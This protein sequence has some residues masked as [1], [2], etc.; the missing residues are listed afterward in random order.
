MGNILTVERLSKNFGGLRAVDGVSF[1]AEERAIT[2]LIGPNGAGKTTVFNLISGF[3]PTET[4][5]IDFRGDPIQ[6]LP[7]FAIARKGIARTFQDP[8]IFPSET[9]L[10]NVIVGIRQRGEHPFWALLGGPRIAAERRRVRG[11]AE[12]ILDTVGLLARARE[13]AGDLSFGEQRFLSIARSLV[14]DPALILM[15]EPTVGL[16]RKS[17]DKL[18]ALMTRLVTVDGKALLVIE[19]NMDVVMSV[20]AKVVLLVQGGVVASGV[21][22]EVKQHRSMAEAYLGTKHAAQSL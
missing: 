14:C 15:D 18:L 2:S 20:S 5:T 22:E 1:T 6:A 11:R 7:P 9:V 21:P 4:G 10:D 12:A 8:R 17:L 16:D 13:P 3:L 19:H